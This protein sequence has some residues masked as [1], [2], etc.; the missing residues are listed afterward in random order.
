M[1]GRTFMKG[2]KQANTIADRRVALGIFAFLL[3]KPTK[4]V[5]TV[6]QNER[7]PHSSAR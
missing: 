5:K 4:K 7:N 3:N 6:T 2:C 1:K